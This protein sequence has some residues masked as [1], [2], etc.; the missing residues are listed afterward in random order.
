MKNLI[1]LIFV[2]TFGINNANAQYNNEWIDYAKTYYKFKVP[3]N[4]LHRINQ[5][6]LQSAGLGAVT[7]QSFQLWR[8]G[9][10]VPIYTS[11][12]SGVLSAADYIEFWGKA[13]DGEVDSK[14]Y[15][16]PAF[17]ISK[18]YSLY[19]DSSSY[20]L[21]VNSNA[22][23]NL[24]FV[25][26]VNNVAGNTLPVTQN[27]MFTVG[28]Y[29]KDKLHNGT[30]VVVGEYLHASEY[31]AGEGWS[32][33]E[34]FNGSTYTTPVIN[35]LFP[36][37]TSTAS[38]FYRHGAAGYANNLRN[39]KA[40]I[41]NNEVLTHSLDYFNATI[42]PS[43]GPG[44]PFPVSVLSG[45]VA[46]IITTN[47][48]Q[49]SDRYVIAFQEIT[50]PRLF[51]FGGASNFEFNLPSNAAGNYLE[52]TNF[53]FGATP[54]V[55][56]DVTNGVRYVANVNGSQ[57]RFLLL[58]SSVARNLI[59]VSQES[60]NLKNVTALQTKS[61][62]NFMAAAQQGNYII[63]SSKYLHPT[64]GDANNPVEKYK[65]YRSSVAGGSHTVKL[66]DVEDLYDQYAYGVNKNPLALK[67][68]LRQ[69]RNTFTSPIKNVFIIGRGVSYNDAKYY[70]G[71]PYMDQLNSVPTFGFPAS[72]NLLVANPGQTLIETPIG[73]IGAIDVSEVEAYLNK[74]KEYELKQTDNNFTIAN[75][76]WM[77]NGTFVTGSSEPGLQASLDGYNNEYMRVWHDTSVGGSGNLFTKTAAGGVVPLTNA[78]ME[79]IWNTGHSILQYFGHSS[80]TALEF[81][82]DDPDVYNNQGKY[83]VMFI[84]GCNAGNYFR[85]DPYRVTTTNNKTL[86]EKFVLA[87][88][89]GAIG[90]VAST[91]FGIVSYLHYE[92]RELFK[93]INVDN[94]GQTLGEQ[95]KASA[96]DL[97]GL[98]GSGDFYG[99]MQAEQ[100]LLQ[101]DPAIKLNVT[102][103]KPDYVIEDQTVNIN[104]SFV[105]VAE[106]SFTVKMKYYN[107]GKAIND[108]INI[109]VQQQ[110]P[111]GQ[112]ITLETRRVKAAYYGDSINFIVP[113][114]PLRDKGQNKIIICLDSDNEV[115][116]MSETNNCITKTVFIFED[117]VKP[118]YPYNYG[119]VN[120]LPLKLVAST[121]NPLTASRSYTMEIDTTEL[122]NSPAKQTQTLTQI[123]GVLEYAPISN[124][125]ANKAYY[126]RVKV[127]GVTPDR[128]NNYSF[129]FLPNETFGFNQGH[130]Y[131]QKKSTYENL[132]LDST[133]RKLIFEQDGLNIT[134]RNCVWPQGCFEEAHATVAVN[135]D[136]YIRGIQVPG[137]HIV[138][139][140]FNPVTGQPL[141]NNPIGQPGK[142]GSQPVANSN[143]RVFNFTY[144]VNNANE[145]NKAARFMDSIPAGSYVI[146]RSEV[147]ET[148]FNPFGAP[149]NTFA[150]DWIT[151]SGVWTVNGSIYHKLLAQGFTTIDSFNREKGYIF[152]YK[153]NQPTVFTPIQ[154]ISDG[155]LDRITVN[156]TFNVPKKLGYITSPVFGPA[157]EWKEVHW[158]GTADEATA[159]DTALLTIIGIRANNQEDSITTIN[160]SQLDYNIQSINAATYPYLKLKMLNKDNVTA[161]P[162]Q[163]EYLRLNY[164][165]VPE[166]A[167]A[168]NISFSIKDTLD[169]G[170]IQ[171]VKI[172]FKNVSMAAFDSIKVRLTVRDASG[173]LITIN[174]PKQKPLA[175]GE[176]LNINHPLQT[177]G[178]PGANQLYVEFNP[179][180]DQPEQ[181]FFNNFLY[182][183]FYVRP[184]GVNPLLDVTFDGIHILNKDIV[185]PNPNILIKL[186]DES[187][188][189]ALDDTLGLKVQLRYPGQSTLK[190]YNWNTDTLKFTPADVNS[191]ENT[192]SAEF[193][194]RNLPDG[195]YELLVGGK[196]KSGNSASALQYRVLFNVISKPQISNLMTY[197]NPFTTS[198]AFVFT[199]TGS[200]VPQGLKIEIMTITGKIVKQITKGELGNVHI[201]RNITD[202]K[203]D[204]T[205]QFGSK[206]A[207]G[208]YL[209]RVVSAGANGLPMEK[210]QVNEDDKTD[211]YFTKG[212]GKIVLVR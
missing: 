119:I 190:T 14:L 193:K 131:Q 75:K 24:R 105:S 82:I 3:A 125:I 140:V 41:N 60:T 73:R 163:V 143:G 139:N 95:L 124:L 154:K 138:F 113:I 15:T 62:T 55:L 97:I 100:N 101:G 37:L 10:Q 21:T 128:W 166:G 170:E 110:V 94:Y 43:T 72:D 171:N 158:R 23:Q 164:I 132:F 114:V 91:S 121:A 28:H 39:L 27:F 195:E 9:V 50:Y 200:E 87:P 12:A 126:W 18:K 120:A 63:L 147:L 11:Q 61:F 102:Y 85:Y 88:N 96:A 156:A 191:G 52:I 22:V 174:L 53:S 29:P 4:G 32:S 137:E 160:Q 38:C 210:F 133:T 25:N 182:K 135:Q 116:E 107:L 129:T 203:W 8:N 172:A 202:Y 78:Y 176:V 31:G 146:V 76:L 30:A 7:A 35:N 5:P 197:P 112:I 13:N 192:A 49:A 153:K 198:T 141:R 86:T 157:K 173:S 48:F 103:P 64:P 207:N 90:F 187:R 59:L 183:N 152:I 201:G 17:Q 69:A 117:E 93:N 189:L 65:A 136:S 84:N 178:Y 167:I 44:A 165:P 150:Q 106:N 34:I 66:M 185:S 67:N 127:D 2:A 83:P 204:G 99:K 51:N 54:P 144:L 109:K 118:I 199:V 70:E 20:F 151:D 89:K 181:F 211:K 104:P 162:W 123:G 149:V 47:S 108:S 79:Q 16:N 212:Y 36:D 122:F 42:N 155:V 180:N 188:Y 169:I 98:T 142:Y 145:R 177:A 206:L 134:V 46:N 68:Y 92:I 159:G 115:S 26:T 186:K 168:P 161:T 57:L 77:K 209:Y 33:D 184:D 40:R 58:P 71:Q 194:P 179:D 148:W 81:N 205:D 56:Y 130:Y 19:D 1:I 6:V 175:V 45:G 196:D 111:S 74:I 80:S 208:V